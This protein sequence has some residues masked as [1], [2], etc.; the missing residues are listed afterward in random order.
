MVARLLTISLSLLL[1]PLLMTVRLSHSGSLIQVITNGI[2]SGNDDAGRDT[3][4]L[5]SSLRD[6][7][8]LLDSYLL[9]S[10][11]ASILACLMVFCMIRI[12]T[13]LSPP[14][15]PSFSCPTLL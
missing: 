9:N 12:P 4:S 14:L 1:P 8:H 13:L 2:L 6:N 3:P 11:Q 5:S 15:I 10:K 7:R